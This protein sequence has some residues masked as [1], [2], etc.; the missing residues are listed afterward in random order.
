MTETSSE[1]LLLQYRGPMGIQVISGL[2]KFLAEYSPC[3]ENVRK[4]VYR[5]FI[6]L[7]QNVS[8]YS[9]EQFPAENGP[10]I[11]VGQVF[12][13]DCDSHF[14]CVTINRILKEHA[15][16][17]FENCNAI[18]LSS[19][20]SLKERKKNLHKLANAQDSGAHIGLIM[21]YTYSGN[22]LEV[23]ILEEHASEYFFK[24]ATCINKDE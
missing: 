20:Q 7:V 19:R 13:Y 5:V 22:P 24:I 17:L 21:I 6:E 15:A 16:I 10:Y 9:A 23:E 3:S 11:G 14:R 1:Q 2:A 8:L 12:V 4:K 18:N